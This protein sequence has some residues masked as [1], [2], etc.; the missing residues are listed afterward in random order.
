MIGECHTIFCKLALQTY[1]K[2]EKLEL[3]LKD[4]T[5]ILFKSGGASFRVAELDLKLAELVLE[6][7]ELIII[8]QMELKTE[9]PE[10]SSGA[11]PLNLSSDDNLAIKA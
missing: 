4:R 6:Q 8:E 9:E 1:A 10:R 5:R 3:K 11:L 2:A 7:A